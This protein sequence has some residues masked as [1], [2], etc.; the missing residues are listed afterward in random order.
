MAWCHHTMST[1]KLCDK[2]TLVNMSLLCIVFLHNCIQNMDC[3]SANKATKMSMLKIDWY[4]TTSKLSG[5]F[6]L[7]VESYDTTYISHYKFQGG[8]EVTHPWV[9]L[10]LMVCLLTVVTLHAVLAD[11]PKPGFLY[12]LTG[13][14]RCHFI[15]QGIPFMDIVT[16]APSQYKDRLIYVWWFPC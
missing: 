1:A 14:I 15:V 4:Q 11:L 13:L 3:P 12:S 16:R 6:M 5:V 10:V 2:N 7:W 9:S 8:Q